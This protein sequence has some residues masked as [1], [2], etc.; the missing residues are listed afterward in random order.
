MIMT[1]MPFCK[2]QVLSKFEGFPTKKLET[3][4]TAAALHS[5]LNAM[6]TELQNWKIEA[7]LGPLLDKTERYCTKVNSTSYTYNFHSYI[8]IISACSMTNQN[9]APC[10]LKE[11]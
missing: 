1:D 10:R 9:E 3:M 6:I 4:R 5:K 8:L 2:V 11:K 7:P